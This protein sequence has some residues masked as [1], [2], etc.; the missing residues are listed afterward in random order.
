MGLRD[1]S[2]G[3]ACQN[4]VASA[5]STR[6]NW[7]SLRQYLREWLYDGS[8]RAR[9]CQTELDVTL[10][11]APLLKWV[12]AWWCSGRLALAVDPTLKGD[13]TTAIVI[14][15]VYRGCAIP[16]AWR[17]LRANQRGAWMDP[18]VELLRELAPAVPREMTVVALCDRGLASPKLWK[19]IV[20]QG[21]HPYMRYP[22][23]VTFCAEGGRRLPERAFVPRPDT[24]WIGSGTAFGR[25]AAKRRC[26]LLAVWYV[27]QEEPWIILTDLPPDQVGVSWYALRFW[28][29]LGFKAVKSLGW[30]WHKTRRTD[31]ARISRYWFVLSVATLL[32][33]AYG[34][35]VEDAYDRRMSP[36][37]LRAPP[38]DAGAHSP[39]Q[40]AVAGTDRK[41]NPARHRLAEAA[42]C[43]R[44]GPGAGYGCCPNPGLNPSPTWRSPAMPLPDNTIHT[45]VS[46]ARGRYKYYGPGHHMAF[47]HQLGTKPIGKRVLL[48]PE[49]RPGPPAEPK[50]ICHPEAGNTKY[51]PLSAP[52]GGKSNGTVVVDSICSHFSGSISL[53]RAAWRFRMVLWFLFTCLTFIRRARKDWVSYSV[54]TMIPITCLALGG[55]GS[56]RHLGIQGVQSQ[57]FQ[58]NFPIRS[59]TGHYSTCPGGFAGGDAG[60][61]AAARW[62]LRV[63][64]RSKLSSSDRSAGQP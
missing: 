53:R 23:N 25:A 56:N 19:Q 45:P 9:P 22:K 52:G 30:Q 4:A 62:R 15:V 50:I 1:Y 64:R 7:N 8:D 27:E 58:P 40:P 36:G 14:S 12:L 43:I 18:I 57:D 29:E 54:S 17:I 60:Y 41:R 49:P 44:A 13:D 42:C 37:S 32:A 39:Q 5:L 33:L 35:R 3:S 2:G 21:W 11:F 55:S 6:G 10:C 46:P 59:L 61:W 16:V 24:A 28:I 63:R 51:I 34:T 31:P 26:T 20:D 48:L 38:K 47:W